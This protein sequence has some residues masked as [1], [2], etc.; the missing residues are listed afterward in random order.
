MR[1]NTLQQRPKQFQSFTGLKVEEFD[2]L[3]ALIRND[4]EEQHKEWLK[5]RNHHRKRK[6]GAGQ[7]FMLPLLE[8]QLL[9]TLI[10]KRV[11]NFT[12]FNLVKL[13]SSFVNFIPP[14]DLVYDDRHV[15]IFYL[16]NH[17]PVAN[18]KFKKSF[19][20]LTERERGNVIK[21]LLK[22]LELFCDPLP[23]RH[24]Q[25]FQIRLRFLRNDKP[26][27]TH[28]GSINIA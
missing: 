17:T 12:R 6:A 1:Y 23:H 18:P 24:I 21:I 4:W 15:R 20:R 10:V 27:F 16:I 28:T 14:A 7:K 19:P 25:S 5:Q 26:P 8:D 2:R 11:Y 3:T 22:P 9:V 13:F